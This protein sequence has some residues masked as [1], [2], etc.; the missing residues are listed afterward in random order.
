MYTLGLGRIPDIRLFSN[1][2]Y[3]VFGWISGQR[4]ISANYRISGIIN[5]GYPVFGP[6]QV[7]TYPNIKVTGYL[8][9]FLCVFL[10]VPL[11]RWI[12]KVLVY[13]VASHWSLEGLYLFLG[14]YYTPPSQVKLPPQLFFYFFF[15][16][17]KLK[18]AGFSLEA[19]YGLT[20]IV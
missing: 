8:S 17:I 15:F 7:H 4:R 18:R 6:T 3:S 2:W 5:A 14:N 12:D 9:V 20:F 11:H 19:S 13:N 16:K 1:A 10:F